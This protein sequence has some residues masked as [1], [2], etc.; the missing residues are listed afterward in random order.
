MFQ[1]KDFVS[2]AASMMNHARSTTVKA[3]DWLPGSVA[4]TIIEAP[5]VEIEEF[6]LQMF[7]GLR[8]AI[9]VAVFKS[10][11]FEPL[12]EAYARGFAS[13]SIEAAPAE[14]ITI[15][16]GTVFTTS[17]ER[18]YTSTVQVIWQAGAATVRVPIIASSPGLAFNAAE[19][20]ITAS[21]FFN[22]DYV[23]SNSRIESGRDVETDPE[24]EARFAEFIAS[25]SRGTVDAC[26]YGVSLAA[27]YDEEGGREEYITRIGIDETPGFV[28]IYL[29]SS[30]GVASDEILAVAQRTLNGYRDEETGE[31][32]PGYRSAG[33]RV[34]ALA[35][36]ETVVPFSASVRM[37]PGRALTSAVRQSLE[38]AY[39]TVLA[40]AE[41]DSV[42]YVGTIET[43][44]LG[45]DGVQSIIPTVSSNIV[46]G[47][48]QVLVPGTLTLTQI[49]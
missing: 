14:P 9:P 16:S 41:P 4:R 25:L 31:I 17:D 23:V 22:S 49:N 6:Y 36:V 5:A 21:P 29:Y 8:E 32:V 24:R 34:D 1:I 3:T 38:D 45:V 15:P 39:A 13:V 18:S 44:L 33:V 37:L 48:S 40:K 20:V 46:C 28:R 43:E 11:N 10:F 26:R 19:G 35:M 47:P 27:I 30:G 2:I 7:L 12:P 42:L